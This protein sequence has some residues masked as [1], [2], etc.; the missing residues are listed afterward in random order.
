MLNSFTYKEYK[1][2]LK[3]LKKSYDFV[4]FQE[5]YTRVCNQQTAF[6][7]IR[8]DIDVDLPAALHM[9]EIEYGLG[10]TAAYH[11]LVSSD[12]YNIFSRN[13]RAI[14]NKIK[15]FGHEIGLH[16]NPMCYRD[17][18]KLADL[19]YEVSVL[20]SALSVR[21]SSVSWHLVGSL[22]TVKNLESGYLDATKPPF[23]NAQMRYFADSRGRWGYGHPLLSPE[24]AVGYPLHIC[25]HPMWWGDESSAPS[26]RLGSIIDRRNKNF[27][28]S[29]I[30]E[31][32]PSNESYISK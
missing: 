4:D 14:I 8:H 27:K 7:S 30:K 1:Y 20:E 31:I 21:V 13:N 17:E 16:Y 6:V 5:A 3:T 10:V 2:I 19:L 15:S 9:A 23:L 26:S 29:T 32:D 11:I 25:F 28:S 22:T 18:V 12:A 24:F